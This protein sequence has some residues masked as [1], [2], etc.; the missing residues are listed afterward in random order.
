M[1]IKLCMTKKMNNSMFDVLG[2]MIGVF[3]CLFMA[4]F[5]HTKTNDLVGRIFS[6]VFSVLFSYFLFQTICILDTLD[7][8]VLFRGTAAVPPAGTLTTHAVPTIFRM[9]L[10]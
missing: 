1:I 6:F 7:R 10:W 4:I 9:W 5:F 3:A 2:L 8:H